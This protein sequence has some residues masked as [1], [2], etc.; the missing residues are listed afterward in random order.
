MGTIAVIGKAKVNDTESGELDFLGV[1]LANAG[2]TL[3]TT[4]ASGVNTLVREGYERQGVWARVVQSDA[5]S[6][7]DHAIIYPDKRLL[8]RIEATGVLATVPHTI[9]LTEDALHKY[10]RAAIQ[11]VAERVARIGQDSTSKSTPT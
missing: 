8:E 11:V 4:A 5:I 9:L 6:G 1:L 2:H 10:V 3:V 7:A